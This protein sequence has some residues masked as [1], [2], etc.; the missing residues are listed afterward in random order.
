MEKLNLNLWGSE[1]AIAA[2]IISLGVINGKSAGPFFILKNLCCWKI[3]V[4]W[5]IFSVF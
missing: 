4:I 1:V 5:E 3:I 2:P